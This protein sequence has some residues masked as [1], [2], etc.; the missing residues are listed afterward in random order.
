M[1]GLS[2]DFARWATD[3]AYR[4]ARRAGGQVTRTSV[5]RT[6]GRCPHKRDSDRRQVPAQARLGQAARMARKGARMRLGYDSDATRMRLGQATESRSG[7]RI[8]SRPNIAGP[9]RTRGGSARPRGAR[10]PAAGPCCSTCPPRP[11]TASPPPPPSLTE[12][13]GAPACRPAPDPPPA[14][15][16]VSPDPCAPAGPPARPAPLHPRRL[17][18]CPPTLPSPPC[19]CPPNSCVPSLRS[20]RADWAGPDPGR[21]GRWTPN[22]PQVEAGP[23]RGPARR[24]ARPSGS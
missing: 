12:E 21:G 8:V 1:D 16:C 20:R 15:P 17:T 4:D 18:P 22:R 23:G 19:M 24:R 11:R 9:A 3:A 14:R 7:R 2:A 5:T 10:G 6:G 13:H